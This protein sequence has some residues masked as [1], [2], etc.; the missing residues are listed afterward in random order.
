MVPDSHTISDVEPVR[1]AANSQPDGTITEST[2]E[3]TPP[4]QLEMNLWK[5]MKRN[6][7]NPRQKTFQK[8]QLKLLKK[9]K[10]TLILRQNQKERW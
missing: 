7:H 2:V 1:D 5:Q 6:K 3:E 10:M 9:T 4:Q 8:H